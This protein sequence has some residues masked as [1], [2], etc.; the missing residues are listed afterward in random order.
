MIPLDPQLA[1]RSGVADLAWD[2]GLEAV[3]VTSC[4]AGSN[5]FEDDSSPAAQDATV[6]T[7]SPHPPS[8]LL[9]PRRTRQ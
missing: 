8:T 7:S 1:S 9:L 6:T 5:R 2:R 4:A 3:P